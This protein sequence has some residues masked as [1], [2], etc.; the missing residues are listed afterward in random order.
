MVFSLNNMKTKI[1]TYQDQRSGD[2][3]RRELS[4]EEIRSLLLNVL[5]IYNQCCLL[6]KKYAAFVLAKIARGLKL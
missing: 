2:F 1:T 4:G 6:E 3:G 5:K